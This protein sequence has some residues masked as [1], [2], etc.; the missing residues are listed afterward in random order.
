MAMMMLLATAMV[1]GCDDQP[2]SRPDFGMPDLSMP[3]LEGDPCVTDVDCKSPTL[4]CAYKIANGC[5]AKG[6][7]AKIPMPTCAS[8]TPLCGCDGSVVKSGSCLYQPGYA[9]GPTTGASFCSDG[10]S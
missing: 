3:T 10:G 1:S 9:S 7:C 5:G 6:Q 4:L 2:S 8:F